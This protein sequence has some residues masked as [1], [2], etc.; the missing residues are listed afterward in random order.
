MTTFLHALAAFMLT[1]VGYSSGTVLAVRDPSARPFA[2]EVAL[3]AA[4][5]LA[6]AVAGP[7]L[8]GRW[9]L[10]AAAVGGGLVLGFLAAATS[11]LLGYR[12]RGGVGASEPDDADA[13][14]VRRFLL[15]IGNFQGRLTMAFLYFGLL[16]PVALLARL[17]TNPLELDEERATYWRERDGRSHPS[18]DLRRQS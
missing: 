9:W 7:G 8:L 17:G 4:A 14:P 2:P 11:L 1:L 13:H 10:L 16:T 6:A 15:R 3:A 5:A 12:E 18:T